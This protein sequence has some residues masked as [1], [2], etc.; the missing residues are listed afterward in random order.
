MLIRTGQ[1]RAAVQHR[2]VQHR[3]IPLDEISLVL[4]TL[5][6]QVF[7][8]TVY[9]ICDCCL[10]DFYICMCYGTALQKL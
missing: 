3:I 9:S 5:R 4:A 6:P 2:S 10:V 1:V 8:K 7:L